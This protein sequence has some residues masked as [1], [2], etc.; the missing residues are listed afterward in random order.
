[1]VLPEKWGN[2][3]DILDILS[4][5]CGKPPP[6][7]GIERD[8]ACL[9]VPLEIHAQRVPLGI[10]VREYGHL[11]ERTRDIGAEIDEG[12]ALVEENDVTLDAQVRKRFPVLQSLH[13]DGMGERP[14]PEFLD[15]GGE[16]FGI[17]ILGVVIFLHRPGEGI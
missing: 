3:L 5:K 12:F 15:D 4:E 11:P 10:P 2:A 1:M 16:L 13:D 8:I 7:T 6:E 17:R 14:F 9:E